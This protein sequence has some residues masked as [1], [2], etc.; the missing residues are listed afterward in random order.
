MEFFCIVQ[1]PGARQ[2]SPIRV[3]A[4]DLETAAFLAADAV[5][6]FSA[7]PLVRYDARRN[8]FFVDGRWVQVRAS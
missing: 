3:S 7:W 5:F 1:G 8:L 6:K 4:D 2:P